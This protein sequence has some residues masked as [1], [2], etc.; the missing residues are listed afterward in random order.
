MTEERERMYTVEEAIEF[1]ELREA[2][3]M[4]P[5]EEEEVIFSLLDEI[6]RL[7]KEK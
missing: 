5:F 7:V 2:G 3:K 4:I 1:A 6:N